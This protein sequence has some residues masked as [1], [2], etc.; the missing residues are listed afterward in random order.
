MITKP[1]TIINTK[2]IRWEV[3]YAG[4][5]TNHIAIWREKCFIYIYIEAVIIFSEESLNCVYAAAANR[6]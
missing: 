4:A 1:T 3:Q 6:F 5:R 2:P